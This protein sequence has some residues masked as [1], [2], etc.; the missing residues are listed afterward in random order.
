MQI[1]G[2]LP[3]HD[4]NRRSTKKPIQIL[5]WFIL[6]YIFSDLDLLNF[7]NDDLVTPNFDLPLDPSIGLE[8]S[9]G[10][11]Q[12]LG[13]DTN[14]AA[15]STSLDPTQFQVDHQSLQIGNV[16]VADPAAAPLPVLQDLVKQEPDLSLHQ[17]QQQAN[18][19][20]PE[21]AAA[22]SLS[23]LLQDPKSQLDLVSLLQ[24][25][26]QQDVK[27]QVPQVVDPAAALT[28]SATLQNNHQQQQLYQ[29]QALKTLLE[30]NEK[31]KLAEVST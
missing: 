13:L 22:I 24:Q 6:F 23:S 15:A 27:P 16:A 30:L 17:Q 3:I 12:Q 21:N 20:A 26:Q 4:E 1:I 10:L 9:L 31:K 18:L 7:I 5:S 8:S 25:Q 19:L 29:A 2:G 28:A 14:F 11:E